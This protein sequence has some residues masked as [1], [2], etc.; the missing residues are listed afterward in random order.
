MEEESRSEDTSEQTQANEGTGHEAV[1]EIGFHL[2]PTLTEAQVAAAFERMHK[3]LDKAEATVLAEESPKKISLAYRI[4]RSVAGKRE[5]YTEGYFGFIKFEFPAEAEG[6][7]EP[8]S[9][10]KATTGEEVNA[11]ETMLRADSEVL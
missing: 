2:V 8:Q 1:Y 7:G 11:L 4:E 6:I 3:A 5:K 9:S 10:H